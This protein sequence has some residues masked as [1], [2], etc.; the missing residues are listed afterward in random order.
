MIRCNQ[1]SEFSKRKNVTERCFLL[2]TCE[3]V[4]MRGG[5]QETLFL[6]LT[7]R[8]LYPNFMQLEATVNA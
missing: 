1:N 6:S 8:H 7:H 2:F 3:A 5:R 4:L